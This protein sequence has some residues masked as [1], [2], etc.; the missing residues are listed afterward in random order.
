MEGAI[1][2][3]TDRMRM[4]SKAERRRIVEE[5]FQPGTSVSQV[6]RAHHVNA[7]QVFQWRR[8]YR[9]GL[10]DEEPAKATALLPVKISNGGKSLVITGKNTKANAA[11]ASGSIEI[12]FGY[13]RVRIEGKADP[14]CVRAAM[15]GLRR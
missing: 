3:S 5:T 13:A 1:P 15:E 7:N 8:L 14:E 10:L 6:A 9:A 2:R 12:D 11:T 4:R